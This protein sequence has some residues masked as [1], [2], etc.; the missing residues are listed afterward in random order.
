[1]IAKIERV[2]LL[3]FVDFFSSFALSAN[4]VVDKNLKY[5]RKEVDGRFLPSCMLSH[6][7]EENYSCYFLPEIASLEEASLAAYQAMGFYHWKMARTLVLEQ[8]K[9][10]GTIPAYT[11][12]ADLPIEGVASSNICFRCFRFAYHTPLMKDD[13]HCVLVRFF[14]AEEFLF[15]V[16]VNMHDGSCSMD[17]YGAT[18]EWNIPTFESFFPFLTNRQCEIQDR[19]FRLYGDGNL[20]QLERLKRHHKEQ[21]EK[22]RIYME[23]RSQTNDVK[24]TVDEL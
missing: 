21:E 1:M 13:L 3:V 9:N 22:R 23:S 8:A 18:S 15:G 17:F 10:H 6:S 11:L 4:I 24:V 16:Y 5:D 12:K 7:G 20:T 19:K 14:K 2:A